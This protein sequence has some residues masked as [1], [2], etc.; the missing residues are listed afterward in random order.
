MRRIFL[1]NVQFL[2]NDHESRSSTIAFDRGLVPLV[3][4]PGSTSL[5]AT[6]FPLYVYPTLG[7]YATLIAMAPAFLAIP[8]FVALVWYYRRWASATDI[9][10]FRPQKQAVRT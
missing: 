7:T 2:R 6:V 5:L 1:T 9:P 3:L 8:V 4:F 10:G